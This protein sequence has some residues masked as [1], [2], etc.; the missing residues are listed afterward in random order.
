M[1]QVKN[2][3]ESLIIKESNDPSTKLDLIKKDNHELPSVEIPKD[4]TESDAR[5]MVYK[6][7]LCMQYMLFQHA[8]AQVPRVNRLN[9]LINKI[10]SELFSEE[11]LQELDKG[12]LLKLYSLATGQV[13]DSIGF[14]ERLHTMVQDASEVVKVTKS[15]SYQDNTVTSLESV[16]SKVRNN[17]KLRNIKDIL[18]NNI[19]GTNDE[20][21]PEDGGDE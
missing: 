11:T 1:G 10:E 8:F 21:L 12:Q 17:D 6:G 4:I 19:L 5:D 7:S 15:M 14:L 16:K 18:I 2:K 9:T 13:T 20:L 3:P